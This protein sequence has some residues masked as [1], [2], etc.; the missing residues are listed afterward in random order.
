MGRYWTTEFG[1][2]ED[3]EMLP[4]IR[5]FS[6]L[7]NVNSDPEVVYPAMLVTTGDHD[8]R[9]IPGHSLKYLAELQCEYPSRII[10]LGKYQLNM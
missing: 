3:P 6:P 1:S 8:T 5:D 7:N 9:V 10:K 4:I 2:P